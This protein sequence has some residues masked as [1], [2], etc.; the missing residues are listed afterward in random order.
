MGG[1]ESLPKGFL[2]YL[3]NVEVNSTVAAID[4]YHQTVTLQDGE[5]LHYDNLFST[6]PLPTI[7]RLLDDVP[8]E[9]VSAS[10]ALQCN[11]IHTV[12]LGVARE[13]IAPHHWVYFP[14]D[15]FLFHRI[16][17]PMNFHQ[18]CAPAGTSSLMAEISESPYKPVNRATLVEDTIRDLKKANILQEDDEIIVSAVKTLNPAYIIYDLHHRQKVDTIRQFLETRRIFS[19]GRF[20]EWEYFNMDHSILSGK[21]M[22]ERVLSRMCGMD[23]IEI[24]RAA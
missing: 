18:S 1:I 8:G 23:A 22:A 24:Q 15:Q 14:E 20:G 9:V 21:Q 6:L 12:N 5:T 3:K 2:P 4:S 11:V 17:F 10:R 7:V 13:H 19:C 16:S